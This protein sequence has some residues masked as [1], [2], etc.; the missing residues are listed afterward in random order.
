MK[1]AAH[2]HPSNAARYTFG[3]QC[4]W[5]LD[6]TMEKKMEAWKS[7]QSIYCRLVPARIR[8]IA[9]APTLKA[10]PIWVLEKPCI[11]LII[12]TCKSVN[13]AFQCR[14]PLLI[15]P[16]AAASFMLSA[17]VPMKRWDGFTHFLLSHL[18][19]SIC[20]SVSGPFRR[21]Y[22]TRWA[23]SY[24]PLCQIIAYP[25]ARR[26]AVQFQQPLSSFSILARK[27]SFRLWSFGKCSERDLCLQA[28]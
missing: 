21:I 1:T 3:V 14:W 23:R 16:L 19:Q 13:F 12:S 6:A 10:T 18:W 24:R 20:S 27:R 7:F 4:Q 15:R 25:S 8:E 9:V 2:N 26:P 28:A 17:L 11:D 5:M 22:P